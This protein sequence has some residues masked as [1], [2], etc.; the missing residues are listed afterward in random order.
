M[1]K[2]T[3]KDFEMLTRNNSFILETAMKTA[4]E[5]YTRG[6]LVVMRSTAGILKELNPRMDLHKYLEASN[7]FVAWEQLNAIRSAS[8]KM[9]LAKE[10]RCLVSSNE[11]KLV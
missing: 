8:G 7:Y 4:D 2:L 1:S 3:K 6:I 9:Q 10:V 5:N 11:I